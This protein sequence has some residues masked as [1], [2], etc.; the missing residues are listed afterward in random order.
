MCENFIP[1]EVLPGWTER[2]AGS[3]SRAAEAKAE[4]DEVGLPLQAED[5]AGSQRG[6]AGL[7]VNWNFSCWV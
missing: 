7:E 5:G 4:A 2:K 1:S 3:K 6:F